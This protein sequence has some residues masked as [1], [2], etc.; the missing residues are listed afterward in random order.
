MSENKSRIPF[1]KYVLRECERRWDECQASDGYGSWQS[2]T[3]AQKKVYYG[4]MY[5]RLWADR[6]ELDGVDLP[7][8]PERNA[9]E[10]ALMGEDRNADTS[11]QK[12]VV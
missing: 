1:H 2:Q 3:E 4:D 5:C 9:W 12:E 8:A 10:L 6:F 7:N 11:D